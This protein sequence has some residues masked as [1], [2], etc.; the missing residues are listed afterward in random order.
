VWHAMDLEAPK[1]P[2]VDVCAAPAELTN[3]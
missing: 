2:P 3:S 1:P